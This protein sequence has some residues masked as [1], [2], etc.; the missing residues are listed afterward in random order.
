MNIVITGASKGIGFE[1]AK[2][3][4]AAGDHNIVAIA[5]NEANLKSLKN[6][7]LH[8][9][10]RAKLFPLSFDLGV[11]NGIEALLVK[12]IL[13]LI[14]NV[15]ILI[16]NAG[17][18]V[19]KP[20][21]DTTIEDIQET[22]STNYLAPSLL[23]KSLLPY[24]TSGAH[25]VNI[26]SMGGFQGSVKFPGLSAYS[27]AKGAIAV[28]TEC[29]A[30]EYKDSG[31]RFNCLAFGAVN[32]EMFRMAFPGHTAPLEAAEMGKYVADFALNQG[33]Y[34]NGKVIPVSSTVP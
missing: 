17:V 9:N 13:S 22:V 5:R 16:N 31:F 27:S 34:F 25:V 30:E 19:N 26:T 4:A 12:Q 10:I 8:E 32:T 6:A 3:L 15:D 7:C 18:L 23:I 33:K 11:L 21:A 29:L 28:L 24:L 1:A 20:F 14:P 2:H